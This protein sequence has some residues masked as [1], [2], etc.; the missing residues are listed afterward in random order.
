M[1]C[2]LF[3]LSPLYSFFI[4][5]QDWSIADPKLF[6]P[7]VQAC[8]V[9]KN[10][11]G[12]SPSVNLAVE[13]IDTSLNEYLKIVKQLHE[14]D[15]DNRWRDL[16]NLQTRAGQTRLT[17]IDTKTEWGQIRMLQ[18]IL[19]KDGHAY[20]L[21]AA[22][23]KEEFSDFYEDFEKAI[24]SFTITENL[25]SAISQ[26]KKREKLKQHLETLKKSW[27]SSSDISLEPEAHF[28]EKNFQ[29]KHWIPFQQCI[30]N[31][32]KDMGPFWQALI[33]QSVRDELD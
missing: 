20:I 17:E 15:R 32:F 21:T 4:P 25:S 13:K 7:S 19:I 16:G 2:L 18:S 6:A 5:P 23:L 9:G 24:R 10:K 27:E 3:L 14:S 28:L 8:F 29:K 22:A 11:K 26:I 33:L 31:D 30:L 1:I 12:F